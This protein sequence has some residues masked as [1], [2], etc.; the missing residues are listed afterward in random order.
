MGGQ[1]R[2]SRSNSCRLLR[3]KIYRR[4]HGDRLGDRLRAKT[5]NRTLK[6]KNESIRKEGDPG[7][8]KIT[9]YFPDRRLPSAVGQ[10]DDRSYRGLFFNQTAV[11]FRVPGSERCAH[12]CADS[13]A[14]AGTDAHA[15][16]Y[17]YAYTYADTYAYTYSNTYADTFSDVSS[18][19]VT[20]SRCRTGPGFCFK[21]ID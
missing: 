19:T 10:P 3:Y 9:A 5:R 11:F 16:A 1:R 18:D 8:Q 7:E 13:D 12:A 15:H 20:Y 17:A 14:Y 6:L 21:R 2:Q 4:A